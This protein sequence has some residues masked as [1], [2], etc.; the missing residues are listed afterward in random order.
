MSNSFQIECNCIAVGNGTAHFRGVWSYNIR[1]LW[2]VFAMLRKV[3]LRVQV[4]IGQWHMWL[5]LLSHSWFSVSGFSVNRP[6]PC[7][8]SQNDSVK[9]VWILRLLLCTCPQNDNVIRMERM[10]LQTVKKVKKGLKDCYQRS[11]P[12]PLTNQLT[13]TFPARSCWFNHEGSREH[14]ILPSLHQHLC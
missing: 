13:I 1:L 9:R 2:N 6:V 5:G 4:L 7:Y 10:D 8:V 12:L 11:L 3:F 14:P